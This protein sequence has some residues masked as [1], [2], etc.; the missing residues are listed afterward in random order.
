MSKLKEWLHSMIKQ[1]ETQLNKSRKV[2]PVRADD[3]SGGT[4]S[5]IQA[6]DDKLRVGF[7]AMSSVEIGILQRR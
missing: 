4:L 2:I 7:P 5:Q 6:A 1:K 3:D